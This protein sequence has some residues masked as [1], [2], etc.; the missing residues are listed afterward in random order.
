MD[1]YRCRMLE[2]LLANPA[3]SDIYVPVLESERERARL[4]LDKFEVER[5]APHFSDDYLRGYARGLH[6]AIHRV[7]DLLKENEQAALDRQ[8]PGPEPEA[9]GSP[10]RE[11]E[12]Q[13][14]T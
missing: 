14:R 7:E 9:V 10:Y 11:P 4:Q 12:V 1:E 13:G 6:F 2:G 3:W 8:P 5:P